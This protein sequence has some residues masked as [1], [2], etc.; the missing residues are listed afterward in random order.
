MRGRAARLTIPEI[1][2]LLAAAGRP[3]VRAEDF[4]PLP[5]SH[6]LCFSL[7]FYLMLDG[8]RSV[9]LSQLVE[10]PRWLDAVANRTIFGLDEEEHERMK[11]MIYDLWS[12]P[13]AAA[14][15]SEA[16]MRTLRGLLDEMAVRPV[17][18]PPGVPEHRAAGQVDLHPRLSGRGDLRPGPRAPL[19]QRLSAARRP[20]DARVRAQCSSAIGESNIG[21]HCA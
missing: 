4:Q 16:V 10:A 12:G 11:D 5:C 6:P 15:D 3:E 17:R 2:R 21:G 1:V 7:A 18:L 19:L 8:G 9:S 20:V 13:A 14:P